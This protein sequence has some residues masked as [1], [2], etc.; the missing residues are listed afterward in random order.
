MKRSA[1]LI[2]VAA[3]CS[4]GPQSKPVNEPA[5]GAIGEQAPP[6]SGSAVAPV[7]EPAPIDESA[8]DRSVDP[9]TDFYQYACGSWLKKTPIPED[10]ARWARSFDEIHQ[11]NEALLHDILE[12]N[13]QGAG[14]FFAFGSQ[15][16]FKD[17]TQVI[18]GA[19]QGGLGLPDRD[20]YLKD[21]A[22]MKDLR[23]LYQDHAAKMLVLAGAPEASARKQA[24]TVMAIETALAKASMDKVER[25]DPNKI[26][27]RLER[28]GLMKLAP[29]FDWNVYFTELGTPDVQAI[30]VLVPG[31]FSGMDKLVAQ[32]GKLEDVKTYLRWKAIEAA[33]PTLGKP[34]VEERFR[35]TK[36]LTG[37]KAILPRWK[38]CVQMTDRALGEALGRSFV[39]TTI[40]DD[41]KKIAKDMIEGIEGAFGRNLEQVEWMD[42]AARAA[43]KEKLKKINNKVGY[44]EK[45]RDYSSMRICKESLLANVA[46]A[47]L[48][49]TRRDLYKRGKAV[50]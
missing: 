17:A 41:G 18:G 35:L 3:A 19:D 6:A 26:Y 31:F 28:I 22:R 9:C 42:D 20:Y 48:F 1:V 7:Q 24:Q 33:A 13:A 38:R 40:G 10:R 27:H 39:T 37:A 36:A 50:A 8:M 43:S 21:D 2:L 5:T 16:D 49:E 12:K 15:Q 47:A 34:F 46:E 29:R 11:R 30:N 25:R 45:W 23:A 4:S 14:A 44:P 32:K